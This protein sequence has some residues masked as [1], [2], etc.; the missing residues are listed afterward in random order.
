MAIV[1]DA[2]FILGFKRPF[3]VCADDNSNVYV[4]DI[5]SNKVSIL[6]KNNFIREIEH[7]FRGP[8]SLFYHNGRVLISEYYGKEVSQLDI[9]DYSIK[10]IIKFKKNN[11]KSLNGPAGLLINEDLIYVCDCESNAI[12]RFSM[13]GIYHSAT[14]GLDGWSTRDNKYSS[15]N[16][17]HSL[18]FTD[19][20]DIIICDTWNNRLAILDANGVIKNFVHKYFNNKK[21]MLF[22][23]PVSIC[24]FDNKFYI[25]SEYGSSS[26]LVFNKQFE[27]VCDLNNNSINELNNR[28][29]I[30][31][32]KLSLNTYHPYDVKSYGNK[33]LIADTDNSRIIVMNKR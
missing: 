4:A 9:L 31:N 32:A 6:Q 22:N 13:D 19:N 30:E 14:T 12:K 33:I 8:H 26:L 11:Y 25:V 1:F 17:P 15:F 23:L 27:L 2:S 18:I 3:G 28:L 7:S 16:K 24:E 20:G 29:L 5:K 21:F 10:N